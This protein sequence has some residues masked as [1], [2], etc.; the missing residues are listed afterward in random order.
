MIFIFFKRIQE[1]MFDKK[2]VYGIKLI[3][4][5]IIHISN[6]ICTAYSMI[7]GKLKNIYSAIQVNITIDVFFG[8]TNVRT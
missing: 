5:K 6:N 7:N 4:L 2:T 3:I 8:S 1:E